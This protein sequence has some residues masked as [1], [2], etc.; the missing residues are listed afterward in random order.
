MEAAV[1]H[2]ASLCCSLLLNS[3]DLQHKISDKSCKQLPAVDDTA[4]HCICSRRPFQELGLQTRAGLRSFSML[5][6]GNTQ[7]FVSDKESCLHLQ[8]DSAVTYLQGS[9]GEYVAKVYKYDPPG[10]V[11]KVR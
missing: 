7:T 6:Q 1:S 5:V 8:A 11:Y 2:L 10:S 3:L 9:V 4:K